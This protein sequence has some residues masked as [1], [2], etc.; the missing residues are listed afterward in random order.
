MTIRILWLLND[1]QLRGSDVEQLRKLGV[2]KIYMPKTL[3][4]SVED[5]ACNVDYTYDS[6]LDIPVDDLALLNQQNWY[7]EPSSEAWEIANKHF[8][9]A[10]VGPYASQINAVVCNFT[11]AIVLRALG[12]PEGTSYSKKLSQLLDE[13]VLYKIKAL[14]KRFWFGSIHQH[15]VNY[16]LDYLVRRYCAMPMAVESNDK[17]RPLEAREISLA[18]HCP[19]IGVSEHWR[20]IYEDLSR[21]FKDFKYSILGIQP[22]LIEDEHVLNSSSG[23]IDFSMLKQTKVLFYPSQEYIWTD[24]VPLR[25]M[26][27]GTLV[28]FMAG[29]MLDALGGSDFIGRCFTI[30]EAQK[31]VRAIIKGDRALIRKIQADQAGFIAKFSAEAVFRQWQESWGRIL[32]ELLVSRDESLARPQKRKKIAVIVPVK[33]RGG[34]LRGAK[35][36]AQALHEGSRQLNEAADIIFCHLD[37]KEAYAE[38]SFGDMSEEIQRRA[39]RWRMLDSETSQR[40]MRYSGLDNWVAEYSAY[41]VPDD[42]IK[43]LM[44]CDLWLVISDRLEAPLL[45]LRPTIHMVYDYLQR[46][47]PI[48]KGG[49]DSV[50]INAARAAR[51]VLVTT[52]FTFKDALQYAGVSAGKVSKVPMLIPEFWKNKVDKQINA[53]PYFIWTTNVS[54]HKNHEN[55]FKALSIYYERLNGIMPCVVTGVGTSGFLKN[56][57]PHLAPAISIIKNSKKLRRYISWPGELQDEEYQSTLANSCFLWHAGTIDNGTF[58]VVE[59]AC[60][61]VP[62]LSSDY[63]A[64]REIDRG[65]SLGLT[66]MK[67]NAPLEMAERLKYMEENYLNLAATLPALEKIAENNVEKFASEYWREVRSCL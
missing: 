63:P 2:T 9:V 43:Q 31:K 39:Y 61:G 60:F 42:G 17:H 52:D 26:A 47:V 16:E 22:T 38:D 58:S 66:W 24:D 18:F 21:D 8:D 57:M 13:T 1:F 33:Y 23:E 3:P 27:E 7:A 12:F 45:P 14:G 44:D 10:F 29:G 25:A 19:F 56:T 49:A 51:K 64:M 62:A 5:I 40:A 46:Y 67:S 53:R 4:L 32:A 6:A 41:C 55:A 50:F 36:L 35:L 34:S 28:V 65:F 54:Q 15:I 48:L 20:K 59:A 11:G 37:D 30:E